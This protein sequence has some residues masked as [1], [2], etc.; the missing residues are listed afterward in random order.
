MGC[1]VAYALIGVGCV[2]PGVLLGPASGL[3]GPVH[4]FMRLAGKLIGGFVSACFYRY[5]GIP[6]IV[7]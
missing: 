1:R 6:F 5:G 2:L 3:G 7:V 4:G